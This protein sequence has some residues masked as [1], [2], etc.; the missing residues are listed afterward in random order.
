MYD[1]LPDRIV[2]QFTDQFQIAQGGV[3]R[4]PFGYGHIAVI[5][6]QKRYVYISEIEFPPGVFV[7]V[8]Q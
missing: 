8:T 2:K 3:V 1:L 4:I 6:F 5:V 7:Q